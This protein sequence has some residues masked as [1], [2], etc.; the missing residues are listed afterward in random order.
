MQFKAAVAL[1]FDDR[2]HQFTC[3][4]RVAIIWSKTVLWLE[5]HVTGKHLNNMFPTFYMK[6]HDFQVLGWICILFRT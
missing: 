3:N 2:I 5:S 6:L 1:R 4:F